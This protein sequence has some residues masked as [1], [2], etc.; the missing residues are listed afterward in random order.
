[1]RDLKF[2][3][4]AQNTKRRVAELDGLRGVAALWVVLYHLWGAIERRDVDWVMGAVSEFFHAGWLGVDIFFVLSGFVITHSVTKIKVTPTFIPKFILRRSMRIDP[5][6][7]AAIVLAIVFMVLKNTFFPAESVTLPSIEKITAHIFYLQDILGFGNISSVFWTLCLEFQFYLIFA[8]MYQLYGFLDYSKKQV[9][10]HILLFSGVLFCAVSPALRFSSFDLPISGTILPYAYE[11]I[12]GVIAYNCVNNK[13][14]YGYLIFG[15]ILSVGV[16]TF[17]KPFYFGLVPVTTI[18]VIY[19]S[20]EFGAIKF[21][22]SFTIQWLGKISYSLYLTHAVVGWVVISVLSYFLE[23]YGSP[24]V[25]MIIFF[26]GL[27]FSL[28]FSVIFFR[29]IEYPSLII[30]RKFRPS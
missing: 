16:T 4:T 20:S 25:T 3:A 10:S 27:L 11:F 17:F 2:D 5:P 26:S 29:L 13:F 18:F 24:L 15:A 19:I 22:K 28:I 14:S 9:W 6:Y 12:L 23:G 7:W 21:L 8:I 30:S 1:M